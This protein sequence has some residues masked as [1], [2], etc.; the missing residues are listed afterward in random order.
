MHTEQPEMSANETMTHDKCYVPQ[1]RYW[2]RINITKACQ[3][4][5]IAPGTLS[6]VPTA[7]FLLI[8]DLHYNSSRSIN[9]SNKV[10]H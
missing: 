7:V 8:T 1:A 9:Y 5:D 10:S 3:I 2:G 6:N 4:T